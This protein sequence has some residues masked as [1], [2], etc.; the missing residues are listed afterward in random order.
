MVDSTLAYRPRFQFETSSGTAYR[1]QVYNC[2][3]TGAA[4]QIDYYKSRSGATRIEYLR[5]VIGMVHGTPTTAWQQAEMLTKMGV[6]AAVLSITSMAQLD[7]LLGHRPVG[8]GVE[9]SRVRASTR[10]HTFQG[11]HRITL[12]N[13]ETRTING[14]KVR[15][16]H[17]TDPNFSPPGGL[18]PDPQKGHRWISRHEL[19][20][21][22]I[23]NDP[24][25][26]IVPLKRKQ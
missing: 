3:P 22:F 17:Y 23:D 12:L 7:G 15:G 4:Q 20:Y 9:M 1:S 14:R 19:T 13:R 25:Y 2:G 24:S 8:I 21:A 11:W 18:R 26:A 16:Y 6:P 5:D 10:G